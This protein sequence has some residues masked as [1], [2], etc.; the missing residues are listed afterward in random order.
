MNPDETAGRAQASSVG[1]RST[2]AGIQYRTGDA[3]C[4]EDAGPRIIAHVCNDAGKWGAGFV[5]A[6]SR[7]WKQP[8]QEYR[9]A[10]AN[11]RGLR[12]GEVQFVVVDRDM[13]V[14][15]MVAQHGV[16]RRGST[17]PIRYDAL[18]AALTEVARFALGQGASV[19][20]PRIGCGL[21]G[22][23]W[24]DVSAIIAE[25]LGDQ[26][27]PVTVYDPPGQSPTC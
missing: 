13:T 12:L 26:R 20:M 2:P 19:H 14:A 11:G 3:T 15:N 9:R 1:R 17:P 10:F 7:R 22:G 21:A 16:R 27:V 4:P 6:V 8:E 25:T 18:R 5:L 24:E 23:N